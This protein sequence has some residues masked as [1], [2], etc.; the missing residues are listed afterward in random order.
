M[1][2]AISTKENNLIQMKLIAALIRSFNGQWPA[3]NDESLPSASNVTP[4]K[5]NIRPLG[6]S[7]EQPW[8]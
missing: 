3:I 7:T 2:Y 4:S 8:D 1:V 6:G 5:D